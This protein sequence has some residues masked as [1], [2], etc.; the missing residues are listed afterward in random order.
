MTVSHLQRSMS[1]NVTCL[2]LKKSTTSTTMRQMAALRRRITHILIQ[3]ID[4]NEMLKLKLQL[5]KLGMT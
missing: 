3:A 2:E 1:V 5:K 4:Q